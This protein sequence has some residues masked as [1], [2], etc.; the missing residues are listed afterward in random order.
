M[1]VTQ[2]SSRAISRPLAPYRDMASAGSIVTLPKKLTASGHQIRPKGAQRTNP[3]KA[4]Q[5]REWRRQQL[6]AAAAIQT[7]ATASSSKAASRVQCPNKACLKP[8]VVDGTCRTCGAVADDSNIVAEVSFGE[9]AQVQGSFLS[10]EQG[11]VRPMA[12]LPIGHRRIAGNGTAEARDRAMREARQTIAGFAAQLGT[13]SDN[14]VNIAFQYYKLASGANFV[15]GRR[16]HTVA[17]CCLYAA[18]RKW[19]PCRVTL[20]DLADIIKTEV[21]Y[22]GRVFKRLLETV[23]NAGDGMPPVFPEDLVFSFASKL[24]FG[25]DTNKIADMAARLVHRMDC[26][27]ISMGRR[28]S[29]ICASSIIMAARMYNY[30]RTPREVVYVAKVAVATLQL[31]LDEFRE[32]PSANLTVD[33]FLTRDFLP[34]AYDPP[35][36]YRK[37]EDYQAKLKA[38]RRSAKRNRSAEE[39]TE[40]TNESE[41]V[42]RD[43]T[44]GTGSPPSKR[45]RTAGTAEPRTDAEGFVIPARPQSGPG[46]EAGTGGSTGETPEADAT[47][48]AALVEEYGDGAHSPGVVEEDEGGSP[49]RDALGGTFESAGREAVSTPAKGARNS[50]GKA[51]PKSQGTNSAADSLPFFVDEA[52]QEDED[53][54]NMEIAETLKSAPAGLAREAFDEAGRRARER[55]RD[56]DRAETTV[57][58]KEGAAATDEASGVP[59]IS[60]NPDIGEDEFADDPEVQGCLLSERDQENK[61]RIWHNH[62]EA[63][64]RSQQE[65]QFKAKMAANGPKKQTRQRTKKPRIGEAQTSPASTPGEAVAQVMEKRKFSSRINYTAFHTMFDSA[66]ASEY[67]SRQTSRAG[68]LAGT[69]DEEDGRGRQE[70]GDHRGG[71]PGCHMS[72][73][74]ASAAEVGDAESDYDQG[75]DD[76]AGDDEIDPFAPEDDNGGGDGDDND[77]DDDA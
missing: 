19:R 72:G 7:T 31:R 66:A 4:I 54:L 63:Y 17:A 48:L 26:D 41:D 8:N 10:A 38:K 12:G 61:E 77:D 64:L 49:P 52:W 76:D 51:P 57:S 62:N 53:I 22:L 37:R 23:P 30:R 60:D 56:R 45:T 46:N 42:V 74:G 14:T 44:G 13:I 68:S 28:P 59:S 34:E 43:A 75:M 50:Q 21:F 3:I 15:Q 27:W 11:T 1:E 47:Q 9:N 2:T 36:I 40:G 58:T 33:E 20:L 67:A 55:D 32:L 70:S 73:G 16:I 18:C 29:G 71:Q 35:S 25:E 6:A 39:G 65:K 5:D 69:E 24:E